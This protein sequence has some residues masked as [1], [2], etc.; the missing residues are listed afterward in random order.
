M[1]ESAEGVIKFV[2]DYT[3]GDL[4]GDIDLQPLMRWFGRCRSHG[5]IGRDSLRYDGLAYGN[6]SLRATDGFVVSATQT[7]GLPALTRADLAWVR[8]I[9][10]RQNRLSAQGPAR[11]SSESMTH[12]QI[13]Q[14]RDEI[15]AV[16]HVHSPSIWQRAGAL[17]LNTTAA[18]VE[19]GTP[20]MAEAVASLLDE[21]TPPLPN[22]FVMLGHQDGVV[23]FG[24]DMDSAGNRLLEI[25]ALA[26][27]LC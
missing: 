15:H 11:P 19:Y 7:G 18:S 14:S 22:L 20:E 17:R 8:T 2:L 25:L 10:V 6:I 26:N 24:S 13:Y 23:A 3:P 12:G 1:K 5:L 27:A 9:D 4:P 21:A 16:I